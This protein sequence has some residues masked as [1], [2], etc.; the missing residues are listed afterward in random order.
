MDSVFDLFPMEYMEALNKQAESEF[1]R[2]LEEMQKEQKEKGAQYQKEEARLAIYARDRKESINKQLSD[3]KLRLLPPDRAAEKRAALQQ[4]IK[5]VDAEID[6][7][8]DKMIEEMNA[9]MDSILQKYKKIKDDITNQL[10][11]K[12]KEYSAAFLAEAETLA[13]EADLESVQVFIDAL[14]SEMKDK[15]ENL[16]RDPSLALIEVPQDILL[17]RDRFQVSGNTPVSY[18]EF[19]LEPVVV[20]AFANMIALKAKLAVDSFIKSSTSGAKAAVTSDVLI[21]LD[22]FGVRLIYK[23]LI[24]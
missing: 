7:I 4:E 23:E 18:D 5:N 11:Q 6:E 21:G 13:G 12:G 1:Q 2:L 8:T 20:A 24:G 22:Y 10:K 3:W 19:E 15:I 17:Y 14:T 16:N 9:E